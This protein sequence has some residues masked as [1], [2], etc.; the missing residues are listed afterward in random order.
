MQGESRLEKKSQ[1]QMEY[2][3]LTFNIIYVKTR[4][5][6][7]ATKLSFPG[8]QRIL[9]LSNLGGVF[10]VQTKKKQLQYSIV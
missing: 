7:V 6:L 2:F 5:K 9:F 8:M 4:C 10:P 3:L 1:S